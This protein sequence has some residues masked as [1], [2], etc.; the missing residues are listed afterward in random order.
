MIGTAATRVSGL[1][2]GGLAVTAGIALVTG[3]T[4][5]LPRVELAG[6]MPLM[7]GPLLLAA[8]VAGLLVAARPRWAGPAAVAASIACGQVAGMAA[9]AYRDWF[10]FAGAGGSTY[11]IAGIGARYAAVVAIAAGLSAVLAA[12]LVVWADGGV[13]PAVRRGPVWGGVAVAAG[14]PVV[15]CLVFGYRSI[16]A[17]GQFAL[18]WSLPWGAGLVAAGSVTFPQARRAAWASVAVSVLL[19][20]GCAVAPVLIHVPSLRLPD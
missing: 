9:V 14:L 16:T 17:A 5:G 20:V 12:L 8:A 13:R 7:T 11:E 6:V 10:N 2:V 3:P 19:A 1:V 18:W 15:L 4:A